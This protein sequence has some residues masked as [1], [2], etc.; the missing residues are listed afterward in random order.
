L[1]L[2]PNPTPGTLFADLSGWQGER[3][4]VQIYN[5][6]G[7]RVQ[8]LNVQ[9]SDVPQEIQLPEGLA[10]GLYFLEILTEKGEKR[11]AR[12]VLER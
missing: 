4:Q 3:L 5:S 7:Q 2:F 6:Q 8:Q 11:A 10:G 1:V 12:F 9:A